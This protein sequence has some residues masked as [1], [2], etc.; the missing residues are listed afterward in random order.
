[1]T[2]S[3]RSGFGRVAANPHDD[4]RSQRIIAALVA[5]V[6]LCA[7]SSCGSKDKEVNP[8][9]VPEAQVSAPGCFDAP[10]LAGDVFALGPTQPRLAEARCATLWT[11]GGIARRK[12]APEPHCLPRRRGH[13][14]SLPIGESAPLFPAWACASR[15]RANALFPKSGSSIPLGE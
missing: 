3:R 9:S 12:T 15:L 6:I 1:M 7:L 8:P 4:F 5:V 14:S 13:S 11:N 10:N 2:R